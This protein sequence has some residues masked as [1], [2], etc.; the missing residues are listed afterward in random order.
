[1]KTISSLF[2]LILLLSITNL[3]NAQWTQIGQDIDGEAA[4]DRSGVSVSL[5]S[6]GSIV[7]IGAINNDGNGTDA[8]HVRVYENIG[9]NWLQLGNDIDGEAPYDE[10]G[11]SVSLSSDGSIVA[12]GAYLNDGNDTT[13]TY[14]GH[15]RVYEY[16][17]GSWIQMGSD[18][19]GEAPNDF[20][21]WSVSLSSDGSIIAIGAYVND[22]N[23]ISSGHTRVYEYGGSNW[24]QIGNDIDGE[25]TLD[26]SGISVNLSSDGS[27]VAIGA[28]YNDG[29]GTDA[30]HVRV[31]QN[32]SGNWIQMGSDIDGEAP[33]DLSGIS[34]S[35]N[36]DGSIVA[37]GAYNN[38]GNG[39]DAGH[40]RVFEY[41]GGN[42]MQI[43][44]DIDG[45]ASGDW[46][47]YSICLNSDGSIVAI[48]AP[49]NNGNGTDAGHVRVYEN[50]SGNWTQKGNDI[51]GEF[52][53]DVSGNSVSLSSDGLIVASGAHFNYGTGP[54]S[55]HVRVFW[56]DTTLINITLIQNGDTLIVNLVG[57][58]YQWVNC[59]SSFAPINGETNQSFIAPISGNYAVI[60]TY[61]GC[62]DT[63]SCY[64]VDV[65]SINENT[66][67]TEVSI[68]PNPTTGEI[69]VQADGMERIEILDFTGKYLTGFENL[70]GLKELDLGKHAKGIYIIKVTTEKGVAVGKVVLE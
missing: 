11:V 67:N 55:G 5:S 59:D 44:N 66:I 33:S 52:A 21:G 8:G 54:A 40:V 42:W 45:E 20:S 29:N 39:N 60:V 12:I 17:G 38:D 16:S 27:I 48:G 24:L 69:T 37:I 34:V 31:F 35:L 61:N 15:V 63:S 43:G 1:M 64:Y 49:L 7:A 41:S 50:I 56:L 6:D 26:R 13:N 51:D 19:D 2:I 30:G 70:S 9:G 65:V 25:A 32:I 57:A 58:I 4:D 10:S 23:G 22:G 47:S 36:S 28:F 3:T 62:T 46:S 14:R 68:Y 18:I 53:N